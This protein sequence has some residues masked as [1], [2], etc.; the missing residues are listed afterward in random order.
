LPIL[1]RIKSTYVLWH[2]YHSILPK[3]HR[4]SLGNRIDGLFIEAIEAISTAA[5]LSREEK[6][7]CV[8]LAVRKVDTLKLLLLILWET[9]SL[10]TKKY[11]ALSQ[12][13]DDIG[14]ML[15]G[16]FRNIETNAG[17]TPAAKKAAGE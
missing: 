11:V 14:R 16:W 1:E 3:T 8:R 7:P 12:K 4:Y 15:G 9:K 6:M 17:K 5:F 2:D 13:V 10:D